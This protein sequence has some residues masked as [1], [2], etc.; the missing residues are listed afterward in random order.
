MGTS[1]L[2]VVLN[3]DNEPITCISFQSD[4]HP[5]GNGV[6]TAKYADK[7]IVNGIGNETDNVANGMDCL[8]AQ[9]IRDIKTRVGGYYIVNPNKIS[10]DYGY[11]YFVCFYKINKKPYIKFFQTDWDSDKEYPT[12]ESILEDSKPYT[13]NDFL[14]EF[15]K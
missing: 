8:A 6:K 5:E 9:L 14:K 12:I 4:G 3:E 7:I 11:I 10:I 1:G 2:T 15:S 13:I